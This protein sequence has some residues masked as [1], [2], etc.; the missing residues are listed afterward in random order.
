MERR[1]LWVPMKIFLGKW[2]VLGGV[3]LL[4]QGCSFFSSP[5]QERGFS[6]YMEDNKIRLLLNELFLLKT[7]NMHE[8]IDQVEFMIYNGR[9]LLLGKV[10]NRTIKEKAVSMVK[11]V[12]GIKEVIDNIEVGT[13]THWQYA[14]DALLGKELETA[15]FLDSD[16]FSQNYRIRAVNNVLY[17]LGEARHQRELDLVRSHGE[18][19]KARR[20]VLH[21]LLAAKAP[22]KKAPDAVPLQPPPPASF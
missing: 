5:V 16:I 3:V 18:K 1:K 7:R 8:N 21:V 22:Q 15:L 19:T 6:G 4:L 14:N 9:V 11:K 2:L 10:K 20:I 13:E 17:I 12:E